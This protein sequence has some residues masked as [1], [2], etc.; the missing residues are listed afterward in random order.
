MKLEQVLIPTNVARTGM[1][2]REVFTECTRVH[3][4]A[5]PFCDEA[6]RICG[7][8][9]LKNILKSSCLTEYVVEMATNCR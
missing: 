7:R 1:L 5:L 9:T 6:G 2:V 4:P 3:V 8:V